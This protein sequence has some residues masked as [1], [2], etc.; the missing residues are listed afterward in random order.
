MC[1]GGRPEETEYG[2]RIH[3][4]AHS[5]AYLQKKGKV[6]GYTVVIWR[7][8]H[9]A[10]PT[11]LS[12]DDA[13]AYWR[14]VLE[15]AKALDDQYRPHKLNIEILGNTTP[16]LHT[17]LRPRHREDPNPFGPLAFDADYPPFPEAQLRADAAALRARLT[18]E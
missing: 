1:A 8:R 9:V 15:V 11:E 2:V 3:E 10:E 13:T 5:D 4:A 18:R 14:E 7:G 16:H 12:A 17:H 6:R